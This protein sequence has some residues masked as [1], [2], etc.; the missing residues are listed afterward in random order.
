[1]GILKE[2]NS[3]SPFKTENISMKSLLLQ[4]ALFC[5][6]SLTAFGQKYAVSSGAW[7]GTIWA[8]SATGTAGEASQ[9]TASD[10][11]VVDSAVVVGVNDSS[12]VC[13]NILF[14]DT[15]ARLAMNAGGVL[16]LNGNFVLKS[17]LHNA[18]S[19]WA[20]GAKLRFTG[21]GPSM[22]QNLSLLNTG[23]MSTFMEI[24]IDKPNPLD[25]VRTPGN[26]SKLALGTSLEIISGIFYLGSADDINTRLLDG[27]GAPAATITIEPN[28]K[29]YMAAG[30]SQIRSGVAGTNPIGKMTI[31]GSATVSTTSTNRMNIGTI[32]VESGGLLTLNTGWSTSNLN[33]FNPGI[34]TVKEGGMVSHVTTTNIWAAGTTMLLNKGGVYKTSSSLTIFPPTFSN[35]GTVR[36]ARTSSV[37]NIIDTNYFRLEI[38][39]DSTKT[40]TLG[41]NRVIADTLEINNTS[42]LKILSAVPR[43]LTVN[44]TVRLTS[45][46]LDN[47]D[48][49]AALTLGENV[50]VSRATGTLVKE[51]VFGSAVNA[52]YTSSVVTV[53][54]GPEIPTAPGVLKRLTI[55]SARGVQLGKDATVNDSLI[56][57]DGYLFLGNNTLTLAAAAGVGGSPCD[58]S[59]VV[60]SGTGMLKQSIAAPKTLLFPIGDTT[61]PARYTPAQ[62]A[63]T[64]GTFADGSVTVKAVSAKHPSLRTTD[65]SYINRY[66]T[67]TPQG[68]SA[69]SADVQFT[70]HD[71]DVVGSESKIILGQYAAGTW[72][73]FTKADTAA[74]L[75]TGT[76][77]QFGDFTGVK[78][79]STVGVQPVSKIIPA[80]YSLEQNYP[81]PF[82]PS[83]T[84]CYG[85]P[86]QSRVRLNIYSLLG[87]KVHEAVNTQQDAGI[88]TAVWN[89]AVSSGVYYYR[90]EASPIDG[91]QPFVR[92]Y[93]MLLMR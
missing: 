29:F 32:D 12:P 78:N 5:L 71:S 39:F 31:R 46:T 58:T 27:T 22:I 49:N 48:A 14:A 85:L 50:L 54:T 41:A 21:A 40:W 16:N 8:N 9:P 43:T 11:V 73:E 65:S 30:A 36:Y 47:S 81:N 6:L 44:G 79:S 68:I 38:S 88:H 92:T 1:M 62:L 60:Q 77:T 61:A 28:G 84:I 51:P 66:W 15:T 69:F 63:F 2:Y 7:T 75:L 24:Q 56:L 59:M 70:Y 82:N 86:K 90:I 18:F 93:K 89:A 26:D 55:N 53:T 42:T 80:V 45:G 13:K 74:N 91:A 87:Q 83:T 76:V 33:L 17:S 35:N 34:I 25:T 52:R 10:D 23:K 37:Q 64:S 20:S 19:A 4:V 72:V 57:D 67:V 3:S